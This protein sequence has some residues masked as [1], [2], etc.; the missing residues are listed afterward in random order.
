MQ[1]IFNSFDYLAC[2][3]NRQTQY[4][5]QI[6]QTQANPRPSQTIVASDDRLCTPHKFY[7]AFIVFCSMSVGL[8]H[9]DKLQERE[10][11][12]DT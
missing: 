11:R 10:I 3:L 6:A 1:H 5:L 8:I 9:R 7:D 12:E 4:Y 2:T